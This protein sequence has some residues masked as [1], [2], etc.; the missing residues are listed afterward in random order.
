LTFP[1]KCGIIYTQNGGKMSGIDYKWSCDWTSLRHEIIERL[2]PAIERFVR[3][4]IHKHEAQLHRP[5]IEVRK[6][7]KDDGVYVKPGD[8]VIYD[9][10]K[11]ETRQFVVVHSKSSDK[12]GVIVK[13][14]YPDRVFINYAS[15]CYLT[16]CNGK[17]VKGVIPLAERENSGEG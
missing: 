5:I 2:I 15:P 14:C 16:T 1:G 7:P 8:V 4:E 13:M 12:D 17:R 11:A 3:E 10:P 9:G 6:V